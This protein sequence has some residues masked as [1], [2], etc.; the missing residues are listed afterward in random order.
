MS[1]VPARNPLPP[2]YLWN[3]PSIRGWFSSPIAFLQL[4]APHLKLTGVAPIPQ[5]AF[6]SAP[7]N[8]SSSLVTPC[9]S[10]LF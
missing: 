8:S 5:P 2:P 3:F 1:S 7:Y 4:T 9:R 6:P 10:F